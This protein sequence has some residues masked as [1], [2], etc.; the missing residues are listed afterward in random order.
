MTT[1]I[2]IG[3]ICNV[4]C[5]PLHG[6]ASSNPLKTWVEEKVGGG[7]HSFL[8]GC[9]SWLICLPLSVLLVLT[10]SDANWNLHHWLLWF[11]DW[12]MS[13]SWDSSLKT[14]DC[15][16]ISL[17]NHVSQ[18]VIYLCIYGSISHLSNWFLWRTLIN[19]NLY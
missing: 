14:T 18:C 12:I 8:P 2:W 3:R 19:T 6:W 7:I 11:S 5:P 10:S 17:H 4:G 15:G 13:L 16:L 9:F 1:S